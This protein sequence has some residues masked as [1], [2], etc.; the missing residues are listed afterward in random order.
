MATVTTN[1]KEIIADYANNKGEP[2]QT[3]Q[4][5]ADTA[6][7]DTANPATGNPVIADL[8]TANPNTANPDTANSDT[9][10]PDTGNSNNVNSDAADSDNVAYDA[11]NAQLRMAYARVIPICV[12]I[13]NKA[14]SSRPNF[15]KMSLIARCLQHAGIEDYEKFVPKAKSEISTAE[16][17][18]PHKRFWELFFGGDDQG[19]K[20]VQD[21]EEALQALQQ[22]VL[23]S[24]SVV[25]T[26]LS[27]AVDKDLIKHFR[28]QILITDKIGA[29]MEAELLIPLVHNSQSLEMLIGVGHHQQLQ[30]VV[31]S[32]SRKNPDDIMVNEFAENIVKPLILCVQQAELRSNQMFLL[33]PHQTEYILYIN[34]HWVFQMH[35]GSGTAFI[36]AILP[37]QSS[38]WSRHLTS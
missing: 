25:L 27:N 10:N 24:S 8:D 37:Q 13:A 26:T 36:Q 19:E 16:G 28:P 23:I 20:H 33:H 34:V 9:A 29:S 6:N 2:A 1:L 14:Q 11:D 18:D 5:N 4:L 31:L 3:M 22:D 32:Q 35:W 38:E 12:W 17:D 7:P 30:P 21:F 15:E